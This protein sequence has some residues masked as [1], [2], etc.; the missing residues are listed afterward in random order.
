MDNTAKLNHLSQL[1]FAYDQPVCEGLIKTSVEDF[2]VSE[3]LSF[4]LAGQG[5]HAYLF[6]QKQNLNTVTVA[7]RLAMIAN[8]KQ[9]AIGYAGL[10]DKNALT[11]QWF[12][13]DLSGK[14]EPDWALIEDDNLNVLKIGRHTRK[15]RRGAIAYNAFT[16]TV[17]AL[18][19]NVDA[20]DQRLQQI[21]IKGVPNY[22]GSQRFGYNEQNLYHAAALFRNNKVKPK[23]NAKNRFSQGLYL[24]AARSMLFNKVLSFR[25]RNNSWNGALPGDAMLLN[26]TNSFFVIDDIDQ[27]ILQRLEEKDIHPSGPLYG[28]GELVSTLQAANIEKQILESNPLFVSGLENFKAKMA[29]RSLRLEVKKLHW[30]LSEQESQQNLELQFE[31]V[32][33]SYATSVLRELIF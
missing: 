16:I 1:A 20:L 30:R 9:V 10:K 14:T 31:L 18:G 32:S 17:R 11:S 28:V 33:G 27:S 4:D 21:S 3:R 2:Q 29:R 12:S 6:L 25:V 23:K 26:G 19:D 15:L 5:D 22:F 7:K 24:S 13:V 8:A